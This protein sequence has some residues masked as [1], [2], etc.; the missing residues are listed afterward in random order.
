M[1]FC[2]NNAIDYLYLGKSV[3]LPRPQFPP[4]QSEKTNRNDLKGL[5]EIYVSIILAM[6]KNNHY[7]IYLLLLG[8]KSP[9]SLNF[10]IYYTTLSVRLL[11]LPLTK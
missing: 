11:V 5:F 6:G 2:S 4:M 9:L 3:H 8:K 1:G 10:H 7:F